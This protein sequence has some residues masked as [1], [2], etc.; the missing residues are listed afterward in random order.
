M[1]CL[2]FV[3]IVLQTEVCLSG[4]DLLSGVVGLPAAETLHGAQHPPHPAQQVQ[5]G[6]DGHTESAMRRM[7]IK[8]EI[9][10]RLGFL[11]L[12]ADFVS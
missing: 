3:V 9:T 2:P 12:S 8:I 10:S 7:M 5:T 11:R 6:Q 1:P 4:G